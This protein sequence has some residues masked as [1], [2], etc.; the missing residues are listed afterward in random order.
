[1]EYDIS[2][3]REELRRLLGR[4]TIGVLATINPDGTPHAVPIWP[5]VIGDELYVETE[6]VSRKAK[7]LRERPTF[8]YVIGLRP[9]GPAAMLSGTGVE[10]EDE[11]TR[12][13]VRELTA[14][15]YYGT[16]AHPGFRTVERQ[17]EQFGGASVFHLRVD[18]VVS[19]DYEKLPGSE[20]ILPYP[21]QPD[22][23][24]GS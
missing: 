21:R 20:W 4:E 2:L 1:V 17:Y 16:T 3:H 10:V 18:A 14:I 24:T 12:A 5:I 23:V 6:T 8:S 13:K 11:G 9:W 7:N 22:W 19:W 15:R